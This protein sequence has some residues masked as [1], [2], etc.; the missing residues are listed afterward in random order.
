[1]SLYQKMNITKEEL[2]E[3]FRIDMQENDMSLPKMAE[4]YGVSSTAIFNYCKSYNIT[5]RT[6][7]KDPE[8]LRRKYVDEQMPAADIAKEIG[9]TYPAVLYYI[10]KF[11]IPKRTR[12]EV[13][14]IAQVKRNERFYW[15]N[16]EISSRGASRGYM[17]FTN[18]IQFRSASEYL[19]YKLNHDKFKSI[20]YEPFQFEMYTPDFLAD[21]IIFEIKRHP[22]DVKKHEFDR[23]ER[24]KEKFKQKLDY[25]FK[26]V[27]VAKEFPAEF[28]KLMDT[29]HSMEIIAGVP[30][31]LI[32]T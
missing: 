30:F 12:S 27:Y 29:I 11:N 17:L 10:E 28:D 4:K 31:S 22:S 1:M 6:S 5:R 3:Q 16:D 7:L 9:V 26:M 14:Q 20:K 24:L 21:N 32:D 8:F 18:G 23:Y 15:A 25:D 13:Q 2:I 19:W